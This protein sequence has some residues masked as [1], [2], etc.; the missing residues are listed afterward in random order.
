MPL[1]ITSWAANGKWL[2]WARPR[3]TW[4]LMR[5]LA[6]SLW[7]S[8]N[9]TLRNPPTRAEPIRLSVT[10]P[11]TLKP[12]STVKR[13]PPRLL[14]RRPQYSATREKPWMKLT[15][16]SN[17][18]YRR[19]RSRRWSQRTSRTPP[20]LNT[21]H[22]LPPRDPDPSGE[23]RRWS[24]RDL[25]WKCAEAVTRVWW[26]P[27]AEVEQAAVHL[28]VWSAEVLL[29][30]L[31]LPPLLPAFPSALSPP[32]PPLPPRPNNSLQLSTL[33]CPYPRLRWFSRRW[34]AGVRW[35]LNVGGCRDWP[36]PLLSTAAVGGGGLASTSVSTTTGTTNTTTTTTTPSMSHGY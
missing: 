34:N 14:C 19:R 13:N 15:T 33:R 22:P 12:A 3:T 30:A 36:H 25:R 18:P 8:A 2:Y 6:V 7:T 4:P 17:A 9:Q 27:E 29:V 32:T 21:T 5:W 1:H 31:S 24:W 26:C 28:V 20:P 35:F 11:Q 16:T 23:S 10:P